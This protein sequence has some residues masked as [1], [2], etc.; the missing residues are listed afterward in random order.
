MMLLSSVLR[1]HEWVA[2]WGVLDKLLAGDTNMCA[3]VGI[4]A[5][6]MI[7]WNQLKQKQQF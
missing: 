5:G 1:I 3:I 6:G 2:D 4:L 7:G